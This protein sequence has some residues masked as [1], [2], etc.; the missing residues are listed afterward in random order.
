RRRHTRFSRDWSSDVCSSDLCSISVKVITFWETQIIIAIEIN[1][2]VP[3]I[4]F[5]LR[6]LCYRGWFFNRSQRSLKNDT[7]ISKADQ[8]SIGDRYRYWIWVGIGR[9]GISY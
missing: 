6:K 4:E 2:K 8:L 5:M 3:W 9:S 7:T 1:V